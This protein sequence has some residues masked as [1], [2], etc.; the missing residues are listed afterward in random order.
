M[1]ACMH[2][3]CTV[4]DVYNDLLNVPHVVMNIS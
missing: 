4:L 2:Q 1:H 3:L